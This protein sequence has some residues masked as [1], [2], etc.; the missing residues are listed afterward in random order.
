M[1]RRSR[2]VQFFATLALGA[3]AISAVGA[4]EGSSSKRIFGNQVTDQRA[5]ANS[6]RTS[7]AAANSY[8]QTRAAAPI[9]REGTKLTA[10]VGKFSF[11]GERLAFFPEDGGDRIVALE[12]L[13][14]E[15]V[16][17]SIS[18]SS[19][20]LLWSVRGEI[21][22]FNGKNYLLVRRAVLTARDAAGPAGR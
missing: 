14:L 20:D 9:V 8:A 15:R 16:A 22:E 1:N 18:V 4:Q 5:V 7:G 19:E 3:A 6:D 21:T 17:R 11:A 10:A 13:T 2:L 12:N